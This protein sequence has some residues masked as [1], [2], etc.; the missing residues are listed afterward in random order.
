MRKATPFLAVVALGALFV[1]G[2][3]THEPKLGRGIHN[4]YVDTDQYTGFSNG[5]ISIVDI[6]PTYMFGS[7]FRVFDN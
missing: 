3:A 7:R 5:E 4:Y 6:V 2:C 1:S